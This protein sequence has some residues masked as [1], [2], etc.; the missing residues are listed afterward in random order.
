MCENCLGTSTLF[1]K[2]FVYTEAD[3]KPPAIFSE[4]CI[5]LI[6]GFQP[7]AEVLLQVAV[8]AKCWRLT[9]KGTRS[10]L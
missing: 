7:S 3:G 6:H 4:L 9:S 2:V 5:R 1:I 8:L 10:E